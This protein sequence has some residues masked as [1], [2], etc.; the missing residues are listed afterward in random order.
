M[1][2]VPGYA[3]DRQ[4]PGSGLMIL[5]YQAHATHRLVRACPSSLLPPAGLQG[6]SQLPCRRTYIN[7]IPGPQ[8]NL[9]RG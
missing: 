2:V 5:R 6:L 9:L 3:K 4:R 8:G 7:Y 1:Q